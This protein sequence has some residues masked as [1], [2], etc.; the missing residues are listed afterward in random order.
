MGHDGFSPSLRSSHSSSLLICSHGKLEQ[1]LND[2]KDYRLRVVGHSL[3][4]GVAS[5][6]S[7][8]LRP[9][10]PKL[11][12]LA[13]SPP[14]CT[15]SE[16][17]AESVSEY[18]YSYIVDDDI[19]ARMSIEGFEDLRDSVLEMVCRV[20]I[21]KYQVGRQ[22]KKHDFST[23]RGVSESIDETLYDV[24][25]TKSSTFKEQVEEFWKFQAQIK[26]ERNYVKLCPPGSLVHL[27]R[28][29]L[30][31]SSI[32]FPDV[33]TIIHMSWDQRHVESM[34]GKQEVFQRYTARWAKRKDFEKIEI[35]AHML[36][37]HNPIAVKNRIQA[38]AVE[39]FGLEEPFLLEDL[40]NEIGNRK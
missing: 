20:K 6:L 12:C 39:Q 24:D 22:A 9:K 5:I 13:F 23:A 35:S 8:L 11:R 19:I 34:K 31:Q 38:A 37:D 14:G 33:G 27:F 32:R 25:N 40:D 10:Y 30:H 3:G 15:M 17:L 26:A 16:N 4:A 1:T 18:T 7:V 2:H 29:H 36:L 21:P 28:T